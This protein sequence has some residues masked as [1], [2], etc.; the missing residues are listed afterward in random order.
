MT[1]E[2]FDVID[3]C[4]FHFTF[5]TF[6]IDRGLAFACDNGR[7]ITA[8]ATARSSAFADAA[9]SSRWPLSALQERST[10]RCVRRARTD[11]ERDGA[12][13]FGQRSGGVAVELLGRGGNGRWFGRRAIFV[14]VL[15]ERGQLSD[16]IVGGDRLMN[17]RL[18]DRRQVLNGDLFERRR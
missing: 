4:T 10:S 5:I 2:I 6:T 16:F 17:V 9:R 1:I 15:V 7:R 3:R 8:A 12:S 11:L 13:S 18:V 14:L